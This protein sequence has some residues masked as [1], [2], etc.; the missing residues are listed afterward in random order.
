MIDKAK[1]IF[2]GKSTTIYHSSLQNALILVWSGNTYTEE[3]KKFLT[4]ALN[5]ADNHNVKNWV[6]DQ[7]KMSIFPEAFQWF[8]QDWINELIKSPSFSKRLPVVTSENLYCAFTL[9]QL[10]KKLNKENLITMP[11]FE[12]YQ[13]ASLW[14][15]ENDRANAF[16]FSSLAE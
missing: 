2:K 9:K 8:A 13:E 6:L 7:K 11:L 10:S 16:D 4:T 15:I 1:T 12:T 3:H 5:F 14:I